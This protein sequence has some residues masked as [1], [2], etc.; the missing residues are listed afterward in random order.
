MVAKKNT[1]AKI[2][3]R[4]IG[5]PIRR[6]CRQRL[7]LSSLGLGKI[8]KQKEL[9]LNHS[10]EILISKVRHMVEIVEN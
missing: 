4:Q 6:N 10:V 8:G 5:S 7:Y 9:E 2:M 3:L 1:C